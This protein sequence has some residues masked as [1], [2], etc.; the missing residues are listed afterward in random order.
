MNVTYVTSYD[1]SDLQNWSGTGFYI[2]KSLIEAGVS[3][4]YI[5]KLENIISNVSKFKRLAYSHFGKKFDVFREPSILKNYARQV[6]SRIK[7]DANILFSPGTLPL[8]YVDS[9]LSKVVYADATFAS[10]VDFYDEFTNL[11]LETIRHGNLI[12]QISLESAKMIIYSS[13][14]AAKSAITDYHID[15]AK[16]RVIP[17]GANF[18]S[19]LT[20]SNIEAIVKRR[21]RS[22]CFNFLFAGVDW[23]R[24]GGDKAVLIVEKLRELGLNARLH[25]LGINHVP[26]LNIPDWITNYGYLNKSNSE[27]LSKIKEL[28]ENAHFFLLPT[29][30][31][32]TPIVFSEANS[33]AVPCISTDVGGITSLIEG[34]IN[35]K[36]FDLDSSPSEYA[37]YLYAVL[38]NNKSYSELALSSYNSYLNKLNWTTSGKKIAEAL[39]EI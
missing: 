38:T 18:V 27:G 30:A 9:K 24:K 22:L 34:D 23:R 7:S 28:F 12:E 8:A 2:S 36:I 19:N 29:I 10:M 25:V 13:D 33:F 31:D 5:D 35:G 39:S 17:F 14:W 11:S 15:A 32:C 6:E 21:T 1:I 3:V 20:Y 4:E 37:E 16:I 26:L